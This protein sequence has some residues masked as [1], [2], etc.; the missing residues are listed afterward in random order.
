MFVGGSRF[1][2]GKFNPP[3][4][5]AI[6]PDDVAPAEAVSSIFFLLVISVSLV[7]WIHGEIQL[8]LKISEDPYS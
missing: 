4:V 2:R 3:E 6:A 7:V 5:L 1:T 8:P